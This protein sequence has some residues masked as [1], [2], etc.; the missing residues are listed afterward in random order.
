MRGGDQNLDAWAG[1]PPECMRPLAAREEARCG[2]R[3][4]IGHGLG[5]GATGQIWHLCVPVWAPE[6][7]TFEL[8]HP[9]YPELHFVKVREQNVFHLFV[10][11]TYDF[12]IF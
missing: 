1:I 10:S 11:L 4:A 2:R 5:I 8:G 12:Q 6:N 3:R 7:Q 9:G